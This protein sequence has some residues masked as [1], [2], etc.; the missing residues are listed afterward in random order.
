M[1]LKNKIIFQYVYNLE[2]LK[3]NLNAFRV[4]RNKICHHNFLFAE[5]YKKCI[6]NNISSKTIKHNIG[7]VK[8]LLPNE[9]R[10][11]FNKTINEYMKDLQDCCK[12][13]K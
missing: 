10:R 1:V 8:F 6:I 13:L 9:Y 7:N 2:I 3:M 4:L 12:I 5:S 11:G